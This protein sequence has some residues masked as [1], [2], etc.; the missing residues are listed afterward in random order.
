MTE[1]NLEGTMMDYPLTLTHVMERAARLF[2]NT[3]I[4]SRMPDKS[5]RR[6]HYSDFH[7]RARALGRLLQDSGLQRGDRVA[8]LM[9]NHSAH[10]EAYFGV[11][12][13]GGVVHTLNLRLQPNDLAY[14]A[15]HASD[16]FLIVDDVL[17]PL[18]EK[19]SRAVGLEKVFVVPSTGKEVPAP[20]HD[21]EDSLKRTGGDPSTDVLNENQ[22]AAMC[23]TSGT[24]GKPKGV[25]YSHRA[26][27]LHSFALLLR[28]FAGL[29]SR[30]SFCPVV[31]MFHVNAWGL[32]YAAPVAGS[33]IV[34]PGPHLDPISL[35]DLFEQEHVTVTAGVPTIWLGIA[36]ALQK[37]PG[38]WKLAK[39]MK[40]IVGGSAVPESL[41]RAFDTFGLSVVQGWGMT[42]TAPLGSMSFLKGGLDSLSDDEKY[43]YKAKQGL[44]A[45]F[46]DARVMVAGD[47][48][49][50]DGK[51]AGEL[52]VRGPWVA[53]SYY[54]LPESGESWTDD[55]WFRTGDVAVIDSEGYIKI[56]D[57]I[58]DLVKS[59]GEWI[60]SVDLENALMGH[61]AVAE[62]VV[63]A[64]PHEK[65]QERPLAVVV[66]KPD[67]KGKISEDGLR[68]FLS[69]KFPKW[70][71]PDAVVFAEVLPKASTGKFDKVVLREQFKEWKWEKTS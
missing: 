10:L 53:A 49:P 35:L 64:V 70:W 40:T 45:P 27:V 54:N 6:Y 67:F 18:Y 60:S 65:W 7:R 12:V 4:V 30:D 39:G 17:L 37:E 21:Y 71:I 23:F 51:T 62:A 29:S 1:Q 52:Q 66:L 8:T 31:P 43:A 38:R 15:N 19:F 11:P 26:I 5:I 68:A 41:I 33:R 3:E 32:P 58:K 9:W 59:G 61:P 22:A 42:E 24:T 48:A 28:D 63:I 44:P 47:E 46:V 36:S 56:T 20:Y 50:R 57:R 14:I 13:A 69:P 16:R 2:G 25:V 55:G 34:F